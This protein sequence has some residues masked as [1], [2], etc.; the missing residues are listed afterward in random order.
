MLN[1][2]LSPSF[3]LRHVNVVVDSR[4]LSLSTSSVLQSPTPR[5]FG[6]APRVYITSIRVTSLI[7]SRKEQR[8][9]N[10]KEKSSTSENAKTRLTRPSC[11]FFVT[12]DD[13]KCT[14]DVSSILPGGTSDQV[15][16]VDL[17]ALTA[18]PRSKARETQREGEGAVFSFFCSP[19]GPEYVL[20]YFVIYRFHT[21][22]DDFQI[23]RE[24]KVGLFVRSI[25]TSLS[26]LSTATFVPLPPPP[27]SRL[28]QAPPSKT[29]TYSQSP[30]FRVS[31]S[32]ASS[33]FNSYF[34][35]PP[36]SDERARPSSLLSSLLARMPPSSP[37]SKSTLNPNWPQYACVATIC[38]AFVA[39][40]MR[41]FVIG[42]STEAR[43]RRDGT[44]G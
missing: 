39:A 2:L 25:S 21:N 31:S 20:G 22:R 24:S 29:T 16:Q 26:S 19:S 6:L 3:L 18:N 8:R 40:M 7:V 11:S 30:R 42:Q 36:S 37:K 27:F 32:P 4:S 10:G 44:N 33:P 14:V 15:D 34:P 43:R 41:Y 17:R 35:A 5:S 9:G 1:T 38:V 12:N 23:F 13:R 28:R